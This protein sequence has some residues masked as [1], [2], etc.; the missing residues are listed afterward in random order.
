MVCTKSTRRALDYASESMAARNRPGFRLQM[1]L[2]S[3]NTAQERYNPSESDPKKEIPDE[4]YHFNHLLSDSLLLARAGT[5]GTRRQGCCHDGPRLHQH[6]RANRHDGSP[7]GTNGCRPGLKP[8][9]QDLCPNRSEE[10]R[11]GK[12]CRS[13]W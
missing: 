10:R 1:Q 5:E 9:C 8:E 4:T 11:V 13:R 6:G 3:C 2:R 7:P 12:E